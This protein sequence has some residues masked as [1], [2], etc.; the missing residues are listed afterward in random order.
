MTLSKTAV[1]T[2][3]YPGAIRPI[4]ICSR[5]LHDTLLFATLPRTRNEHA[6]AR[7]V[8][9]G[10]VAT[11]SWKLVQLSTLGLFNIKPLQKLVLVQYHITAM[12]E[13]KMNGNAVSD[14]G[15]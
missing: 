12:S 11:C 8:A 4:P 7:A 6:A 14:C 2:A 15:V 9:F 13:S 3:S 10:K 5:C 1:C